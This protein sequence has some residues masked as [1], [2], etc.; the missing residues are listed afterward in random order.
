ME[1]G[2]ANKDDAHKI[3]C[4]VLEFSGKQCDKPY[5]KNAAMFYTSNCAGCHGEDAKG[6]NGTF[7]DLTKDVFLGI[8]KRESFLNKMIKNGNK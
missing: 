6:I 1:G 2:F 5:N 8:E 3:S 4:Y 7:P